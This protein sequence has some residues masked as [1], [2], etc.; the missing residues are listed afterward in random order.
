[1]P[2]HQRVLIAITSPAHV[3]DCAQA[4]PRI[5]W[6]QLVDALRPLQLK[7]LVVRHKATHES[8]AALQSLHESIIENL[9]SSGAEVAALECEPGSCSLEWQ[10]A[11]VSNSA[12]NVDAVLLMTWQTYRNGF[13]IKCASAGCLKSAVRALFSFDED[14]TRC[15]GAAR[16]LSLPFAPATCHEVVVGSKVADFV[17]NPSPSLSADEIS[18]VPAEALR[19]AL[20]TLHADAK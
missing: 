2:S 6:R 1:M 17:V 16:A 12:Y 15:S 18:L 7:A 3:S 19:A 9:R 4:T 11:Q 8:C 20:G 5:P 13:D 10:L 14:S